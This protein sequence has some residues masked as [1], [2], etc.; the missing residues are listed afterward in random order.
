VY[1]EVSRL[2][3]ASG[4][5][6]RLRRDNPRFNLMLGER[7]RLP[8]GRLGKGP[9]RTPHSSPPSHPAA[10]FPGGGR[11]PP[12]WVGVPRGSA[13]PPGPR[14]A[15]R[16][17]GGAGPGVARNEGRGYQR[18]V[19]AVGRRASGDP[20]L[21]CRRPAGCS[22]HLPAPVFP[23]AGGTALPGAGSACPPA[24]P[25]PPL[26]PRPPA[27][28]GWRAPE[29]PPG[30]GESRARRWQ[31]C[32][33]HRRGAGVPRHCPRPGASRQE[34]QGCQVSPHDAVLAPLPRPVGSGFGMRALHTRAEQWLSL[35]QPPRVGV[36]RLTGPC[37]PPC[38]L[39]ALVS[40]FLGRFCSTASGCGNVGAGGAPSPQQLRG[41]RAF[42]AAFSQLRSSAARSP[43]TALA[44]LQVTSSSASSLFS[45]C[46]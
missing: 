28:P 11:A 7:N 41:R 17:S 27:P 26:P 19:R 45:T 29:Q 34:P 42:A 24:V 18:G 21:A 36:R 12:A 14:R 15:P 31:R 43:L 20:P 10:R 33:V 5:W 8:F 38:L 44:D 30:S 4:Q 46:I 1:A 39:L 32:G 40:S 13:Q 3:L 9:P 37:W 16:G 2:L 35:L 23:G 6:R 22:P 25:F